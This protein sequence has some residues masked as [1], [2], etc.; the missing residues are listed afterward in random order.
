MFLVELGDEVM[1]RFD[2]VW[3][4][5]DSLMALQLCGA[6]NNQSHHEQSTLVG[7]GSYI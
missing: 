7:S 5:W 2:E 3:S 6:C 4:S 1:W